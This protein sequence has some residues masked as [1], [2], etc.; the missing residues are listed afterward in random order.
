MYNWILDHVEDAI[1]EYRQ[2]DD[3][4]KDVLIAGL[5]AARNKIRKWYSRTSRTAYGNAM[6]RFPGHPYD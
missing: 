6:C 5:L 3:E 2:G 4:D 1:A